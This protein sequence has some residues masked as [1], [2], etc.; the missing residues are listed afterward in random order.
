MSQW[1]S[2]DFMCAAAHRFNAVIL[3]AD[4]EHPIPCEKC[5]EEAVPV[6]SVPRNL[7][8]SFH[9]G[10]RRS[11]FKDGVEA[12]NLEAASFDLPVDERGG[13]NDEIKKLRGD[14]S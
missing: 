8:V 12:S 14:K 10:V 2:Q 5:G 13:F 4:K 11:G 9:D 6:F 1:W 7:R 3:R